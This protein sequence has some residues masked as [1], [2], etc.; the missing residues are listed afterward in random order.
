MQRDSPSY[1][2]ML[3]SPCLVIILMNLSSFLLL[4][5]NSNE[6]LWI[7][8]VC[9]TWCI[10]YQLY[11]AITLPKTKHDTPIVVMI[12]HNIM[13]LLAVAIFFNLVCKN[14]M[15]IKSKRPPTLLKDILSGIFGKILCL[16][17]SQVC[18]IFSQFS[19]KK[20]LQ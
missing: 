12:Y 13:A 10:L 18:S 8:I 17:Q 11:F 20:L 15:Q 7:N 2:T 14:I 1:K 3:L 19:R 16:C 9:I 5:P 4:S 6:R